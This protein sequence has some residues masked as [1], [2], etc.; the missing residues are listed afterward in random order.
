MLLRDRA[1]PVALMIE[2]PRPN[3]EE[4]EPTMVELGTSSDQARSQRSRSSRQRNV[5]TVRR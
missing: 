3:S 2:A 5:L 4:P 1:R